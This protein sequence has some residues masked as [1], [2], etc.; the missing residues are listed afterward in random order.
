MTVSAP[1]SVDLGGTEVLAF[2]T[3][4]LGNWSYLICSEREAIAVDPQRDAEQYLDAAERRG[5]RLR[6]VLETHNHSDY[7]SGGLW[8]ASRTGAKVAAPARG[9]YEF[10]HIPVDDGDEIT[11]GGVRLRCTATPG[12]TFDHVS[13]Q[14]L[15]ADSDTTQAVLTGGSLL[16]GGAGRTDL[17]GESATPELTALQFASLRRLAALSGSATVLPTHGG[18]S[19]CSVNAAAHIQGFT[20]LDQERQANPFISDASYEEFIDSLLRH[21]TPAPAYFPFVASINRSGPPVDIADGVAWLSPPQFAH[22]IASGA[23][24]IDTRNRW[25][26]ADG[27]IEGSLNVDLSDLFP[28]QVGSLVPYGTPLAVVLETGDRG[29]LED[30][31][32]ECL[33]LGYQISGVL[34]PGIEAWLDQGFDLESY[35]ASDILELQSEAAHDQPPAILDVRDPVEWLDGAIPGSAKIPISGLAD[36]AHELRDRWANGSALGRLNV[37]CTGG[38]RAGVAASYLSRLGVPVR[39]IL[40]GGVPD[41]M[42][43]RV[44][45]LDI[46]DRVS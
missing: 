4:S 22:A 30:V 17:A 32:R 26:F 13:W 10:D 45:S 28:V 23:W 8:L 7:L 42:G 31:R 25:A 35:P 15:S 6:R 1:I 11:I 21:V 34:D 29:A 27:H 2:R 44:M 14:L 19:T 41:A 40:G 37:A 39:V 5:A 18:G 16:I 43:M 3:S 36:R 9:G 24:V 38:A 46:G 33:R 12:H 20:S